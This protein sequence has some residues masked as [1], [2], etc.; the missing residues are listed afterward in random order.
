MLA[1]RINE[2][3]HTYS[4]AFQGDKNHSELGYANMVAR[5]LKTDHH[6]VLVT[7]EDFK[8]FMEEQPWY[9]DEP[10]ANLTMV[11]LYFL[12]KTAKK[13]VKAILSGEGADE[14]LAGYHY[15]KF[16]QISFKRQN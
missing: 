2:N 15:D 3:F 12:S 11:P 4:V 6:D 7:I 14:I 8:E 13:D 16:A 9:T 5:H 1:N 10:L